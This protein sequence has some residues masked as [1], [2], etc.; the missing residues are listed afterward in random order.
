[1]ELL[2][3][4]LGIFLSLL[5]SL[6]IFLSLL[7]V[8]VL[9]DAIIT[10]FLQVIGL[11][12]KK[13]ESK[14]IKFI[15]QKHL[16]REINWQMSSDTGIYSSSYVAEIDDL[17]IRIFIWKDK[18]CWLTFSGDS[19][20]MT[21]KS[22]V[23]SELKIIMKDLIKNYSPSPIKNYSPSPIDKILVKLKIDKSIERDS[24][25]DSILNSDSIMGIIKKK[26]ISN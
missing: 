7:G 9:M 25:I 19:L 3:V 8:G 11:K 14:L 4:S 13:K 2:L 12:S 5:V 21:F 24:K 23:Y 6:G 10:R 20:D 18:T 17:A 22:E 1:M 16:N 15:L 26:F